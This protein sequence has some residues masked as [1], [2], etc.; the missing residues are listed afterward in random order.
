[1]IGKII[2]VMDS[3]MINANL[4][5][6]KSLMS[7]QSRIPYKINALKGQNTDKS[8][9]F[10]VADIE[11]VMVN[12]IHVP[13][14]AGYLVVKPGDDLTSIPYYEIK[15]FFSEKHITF[16]PNFEERK[17]VKEC[18]LIFSIIWKNVFKKIR[19]L[20][21]FHNFDRFDGIF[22]L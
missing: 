16:Y 21:H 12:Q 19:I 7:K 5:Y 2:K 6:A 8:R 4:P 22:I 13:Y 9:P 18:Y 3:D 14:A 17:G 15:T 20:E 10:I 1:M 11:T